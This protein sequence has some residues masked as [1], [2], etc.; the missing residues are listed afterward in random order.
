MFILFTL[1]H[2]D[3]M[4]WNEMQSAQ[5][6]HSTNSDQRRDNLAD[7]D[8]DD[9]LQEALWKAV[10]VVQLL[11]FLTPRPNTTGLDWRLG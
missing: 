10:S 8:D 11:P 9:E 3:E 5:R 6:L 1:H 4:K 2:D 7:D